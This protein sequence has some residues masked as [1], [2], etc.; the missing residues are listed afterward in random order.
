M[1]GVSESATMGRVLRA[2]AGRMCGEHIE[3]A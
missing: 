1:A 3:Y 2:A